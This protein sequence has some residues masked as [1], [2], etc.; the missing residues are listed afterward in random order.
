MNLIETDPPAEVCVEVSEELGHVSSELPI[1]EVSEEPWVVEVR[2]ELFVFLSRE[3]SA[4]ETA[5]KQ[6]LVTTTY[7][8]LGS[9]GPRDL[10]CYMP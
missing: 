9:K 8:D 1:T 3:T 4:T 6:S 2:R 7:F 10:N 5:G